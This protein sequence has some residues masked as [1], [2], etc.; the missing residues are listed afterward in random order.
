VGRGKDRPVTV[1][2][3]IRGRRWELVFGKLLEDDRGRCDN[4]NK[5]G[6]RI[7]IDEDLCG[8]ELIEVLVHEAIHASSWDL[9]EDAV[10]E[11]AEG[12]SRLLWKLGYR[13]QE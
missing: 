1:H 12:I 10:T 6:K 5:K 7:S 4:P 9:D 8:E 3:L 11:T 2:V 13:R